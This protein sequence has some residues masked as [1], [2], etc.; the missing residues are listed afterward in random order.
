[1][2]D[3]Y[4]NNLLVAIAEEDLAYALY[5]QEYNSGSFHTAM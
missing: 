5:V 3:N 4:S 2:F 1:M